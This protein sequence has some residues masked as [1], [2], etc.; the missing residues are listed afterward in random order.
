M[1]F[2]LDNPAKSKKISSATRTQRQTR[3]GSSGGVQRVDLR[4]CDRQI[5]GIV[6]V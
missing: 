1:F 3:P 5:V 4:G 2:F 6:C